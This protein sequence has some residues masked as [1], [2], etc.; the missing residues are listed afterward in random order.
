MSARSRATGDVTTPLRAALDLVSEA[1]P[2]QLA[3]E[4]LR[5][6]GELLNATSS[7][8]LLVTD[9]VAAAADPGEPVDPEDAE[10]ALTAARL[11]SVQLSG[12]SAPVRL[13]APLGRAGGAVMVA[14]HQ[15]AQATPLA[16][17]FAQER[18]EL[19]GALARALASHSGSQPAATFV[20]ALSRL[21][22]L[23]AEA[24]VQQM[25]LALKAELGGDRAVVGFV[26]ALAI[27][28]VGDSSATDKLPSSAVATLSLALGEVVDM[29]GPVEGPGSA[30]Q[31]FETLVGGKQSI[32]R[33]Q[34][35]EGGD[36]LAV[37]LL[38]EI[39]RQR[40]AD[41]LELASAVAIA[42]LNRVSLSG[43]FDA[44]AARLPWPQHIDPDRRPRLARRIMLGLVAAILLLPIPASV[45][46]PLSIEPLVKRVV[47]AP[48]SAR[49]D[50]VAVDPGD[51]VKAGDLLLVLDTHALE[52]ERDEAGASLQAAAVEQS[53]ARDEG[54]SDAARLAELRM[55]QVQANL[56]ALEGRI[57]EGQVVASMDGTVGGADLKQ[58]LGATVS[59]GEQLFTLSAGNGM[60][61][62]LMVPDSQIGRVQ[63]GD[64][65]SLALSAHPFSR[66]A[67][68]V[69]RIYPVAEVTRSSNAFRV[70]AKLDEDATNL[71]PGME[72]TGRIRT[73]WRPL[74]WQ[75]AEPAVRWLRLRLWI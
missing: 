45:N 49:I 8:L 14:V 19:T 63:I 52:R 34:L 38:G 73:G 62:D 12:G 17:A 57:A 72:G 54:D 55:A 43:R 11:G 48:L 27:V 50:R 3:P 66:P 42:R 69:S 58:R 15:L 21:A 36:G 53:R 70:I 24:A 30:L 23:P 28:A 51:K 67:A 40:L 35:S 20:A 61:A 59:R 44:L 74:A 13:A 9:G 56:A 22:A 39:D 18:L 7:Q 41:R 4:L 16:V 33:A 64:G 47:T 5:L 29:P 71:R 32:G 2:A 75:I 31:G 25:A 60:R 68:T 37:I 65:V 1:P 26:R 10:L 6:Q 46:A